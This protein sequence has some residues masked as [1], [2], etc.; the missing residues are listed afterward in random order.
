MRLLFI[1]DQ[2]PFPARNGVT[3][4]VSNYVEGFI[5]FGYKV[6]LI[7][8]VTNDEDWDSEMYALNKKKFSDIY[9]LYVEKKSLVIRVIKELLLLEPSFAYNGP[10]ICLTDKY[11][12]II[13][14]PH[15]PALFAKKQVLKKNITG[16]KLI[17]AVSDVYSEL[18]KCQV[19]YSFVSNSLEKK[20]ISI[21]AAIR[22]YIIM[23]KIECNILQ[24]FDYVVVQTE[25][26]KR[27][28]SKV[29]KRVSQDKSI[30]LSNGVNDDLFDIDLR[31]NMISHD[32]LY[33]GGVD[34]LVEN[35]IRIFVEKPYKVV[36]EHVPDVQFTFVN[37]KLEKK[38]HDYLIAHK[39]K[40]VGYVDNI[41]DIY[42]LQ[43]ILIAPM[44]K[45]FG[46]INKVI[47][48]M[49]SGCV[50]VGDRY[51]F[52]GIPGFKDKK[53][54]FVVESIDEMSSIILRIFEGYEGINNVR[55]EARKL[56]AKNFKWGDRVAILDEII[57]KGVCL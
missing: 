47:E 53:H 42:K 40:C 38:F 8:L 41:V 3:L 57:K 5:R 31:E 46:L 17:A 56:V 6:D 32:I 21:F 45:G 39:V 54:G 27:Y 34:E 51:A 43:G 20:I 36:K 7:F 49:A 1:V 35:N 52:N 12:A 25:T 13:A 37:N 2:L 23:P 44:F 22:A 19:R 18:L 10:S 33:I 15:G 55:M 11:D 4:P 16:K 24:M 26:D 50:V 30:V 14:S 29:C 28:L 48:A 9:C